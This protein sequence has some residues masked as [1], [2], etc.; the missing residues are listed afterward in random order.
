MVTADLLR[1]PVIVNLWKLQPLSC[2][3]VININLS[4]SEPRYWEFTCFSFNLASNFVV[5]QRYRSVPLTCAQCY[6]VGWSFPVAQRKTVRSAFALSEYCY[7]KNALLVPLALSGW[8]SG[9]PRGPGPPRGCPRSWCSGPRWRKWVTSRPTSSML[10]RRGHT[11]QASPRWGACMA[12]YLALFLFF[13]GIDLIRYQYELT[14]MKDPALT[15]WEQ[16]H[17]AIFNPFGLNMT[18]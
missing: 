17:A 2:L 1:V 18:T 5:S 6:C 10:R 7:C 8:T 3:C 4:R 14:L 12:L 11:R 9:A 15:C 13:F 16:G